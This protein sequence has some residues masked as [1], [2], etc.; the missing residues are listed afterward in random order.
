MFEDDERHSYGLNIAI[1]IKIGRVRLSK[2]STY[3]TH[4]G[5]S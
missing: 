3:L 5:F 2:A 1:V 4:E